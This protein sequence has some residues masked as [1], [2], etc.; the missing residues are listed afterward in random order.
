MVSF[1]I[2]AVLGGVLGIFTLSLCAASKRAD[3]GC[4]EMSQKSKK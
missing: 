1:I 2:G 3:E 4:K